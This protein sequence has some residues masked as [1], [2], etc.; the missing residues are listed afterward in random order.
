MFV[1]KMKSNRYRKSYTFILQVMKISTE[2]IQKRVRVRV[3]IVFVHVLNLSNIYGSIL[4]ITCVRCLLLLCAYFTFI[5]AQHPLR[6]NNERQTTHLLHNFIA[7]YGQENKVVNDYTYV[8][9]T[10]C[11]NIYNN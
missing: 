3:R 9:Y 7:A 2:K 4:L 10:A 8:L 5:S 11:L 1:N 6:M